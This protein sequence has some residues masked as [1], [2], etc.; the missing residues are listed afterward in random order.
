MTTNVYR[1]VR[2]YL[3]DRANEGVLA[4]KFQ[5]GTI[6]YDDVSDKTFNFNVRYKQILTLVETAHPNAGDG[7][8]IVVNDAEVAAD[9]RSSG[10]VVMT[11]NEAVAARKKC[12]YYI[13]LGGEE[14]NERVQC[15]YTVWS[16]VYEHPLA[17]FMTKVRFGIDGTYFPT[18]DRVNEIIGD[19]WIV[20]EYLTEVSATYLVRKKPNFPVYITNQLRYL[21][22]RFLSGKGYKTLDIQYE[23]P[24]VELI[25]IVNLYLAS[26]LQ[27]WK[28]DKTLL[29]WTNI[30]SEIEW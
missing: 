6:T 14:K 9:F 2:F 27:Q 7:N 22:E 4:K 11:A 10:F 16:F 20:K 30:V 25:Y 24:R 13:V 3:N 15:T 18:E 5:D 26:L 21:K 17:E 19:Y 28:S 1:Y 12:K 8:L 29:H 23:P